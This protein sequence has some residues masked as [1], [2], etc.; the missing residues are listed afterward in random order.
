MTPGEL[1]AELEA[2]GV[3]LHVQGGFLR[4]KGVRSAYDLELK[5]EVARLRENILADWLC[6]RCM[7]VVRVLYGFPP[8]AVCRSCFEDGKG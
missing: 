5:A 4:C 8:M 6:P 3:H 1:L 2:R 7:H